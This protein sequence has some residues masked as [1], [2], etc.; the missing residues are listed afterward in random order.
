VRW[1]Q[2]EW[3]LAKATINLAKHG[4]SFEEAAT[5]FA[6]PLSLTT[7]DPDHSEDEDRFILVGATDYGRLV[8]VIHTDRDDSVRIISAR[9]ATR[10]ERKTYE[11]F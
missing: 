9:L 5:A 2:F 6:D 1:I 7:Y 10:A 8:V 3:D 11:N 4:V